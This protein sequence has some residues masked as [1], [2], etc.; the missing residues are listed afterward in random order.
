MYKDSVKKKK[1]GKEKTRVARS[2]LLINLVKAGSSGD[3]YLFKQTVQ[4]MIAEESAKQH[5][6]LADR[7]KESLNS[8]KQNISAVQ[9]DKNVNTSFSN[10]YEEII[11]QLT[12]QDLVLSSDN[13]KVL[14]E[15]VE[16]QLRA[17]LLYSYNLKPRH[18][19]LLM[20]PPGNGKTSLAEAMAN[21]LLVNLYKVRYENVI[22]SFLGDTASK[23]SV[24]FSELSSQKCVLFLDE[25]DVLAK[26]RGDIHETGEIKRVVSTLLMLIDSLPPHV[27]LVAATNHPELLDS[28]SWRRFQARVELQKPSLHEIENY[29]NKFV[30]NS[31]VEWNISVRAMAAKLNNKSFAEV[32]DF[33]ENV[34]RRFVLSSGS[35]SVKEIV[36]SEIKTLG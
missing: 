29:L 10:F 12:F 34:M 35:K 16:E 3:M 24:L 5:H 2:D 7:L 9:F 20:G 19:I 11:P 17:E 26:E 30:I 13:Q 4:A 6:A 36:N 1:N 27:I 31:N 28:A 22:S 18:R 14:N 25:F 21:S 15:I 8:S 33:C 32:K 23:L